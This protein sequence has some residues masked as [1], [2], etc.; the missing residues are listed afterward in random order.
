[1]VKTIFVFV[2]TVQS[3]RI[4]NVVFETATQDFWLFFRAKGFAFFY[5]QKGRELKNYIFAAIL[6]SV[7]RVSR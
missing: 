7:V 5:F 3:T 4:R 1:M 2:S 6:F